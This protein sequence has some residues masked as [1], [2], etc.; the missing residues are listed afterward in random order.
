MEDIAREYNSAISGWVNYYAK[1]GKSEFRLVMKYLNDTLVKWVKRKYKRFRTKLS[2]ANNW[3]VKIAGYNKHLFA[4]WTVGY[5][6]YVSY[7][8]K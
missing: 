3:L 4:H 6:P 7:R 1:R 8:K 5:V 2:K